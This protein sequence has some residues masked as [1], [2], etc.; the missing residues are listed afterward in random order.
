VETS[1]L[2]LPL[3][4]AHHLLIFLLFGILVAELVLTRAASDRP[5]LMLVARIDLWYGL[6]AVALLAVGFVRAIFA[7]KGWAYYQ[8]NLFFWAKIATFFLIALLSVPPTIAY[9]RWKVAD[10]PDGAVLARMRL[11]LWLQAALF[12]LLL[13]FAAA[14]ARG[15]GAGAI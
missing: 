7:A 5:S 14:M 2:D 6:V 3:A 11:F 1:V 8:H 10:A 9:L 15:Y 12:P 4:I 13:I